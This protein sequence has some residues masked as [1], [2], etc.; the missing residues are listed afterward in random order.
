[1][2]ASRGARCSTTRTLLLAFSLLAGLV[3]LSVQTSMTAEL[4]SR[5][6][7]VPMHEVLDGEVHSPIGRLLRGRACPE[8]SHG[9][10]DEEGLSRLVD[11]LHHRGGGAI[12]M[13]EFERRIP[14]RAL[15]E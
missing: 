5:P 13:K 7:L 14:A 1:M 3:L 8:P 11:W 15:E 10:D 9:L 2:P 12:L 4:A 6:P